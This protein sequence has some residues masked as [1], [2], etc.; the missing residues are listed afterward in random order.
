VAFVGFSI[1]VCLFKGPREPGWFGWSGGLNLRRDSEYPPKSGAD[2][3]KAV[4]GSTGEPAQEEK[5]TS[6]P[7]ST[8][9]GTPSSPN[10]TKQ[11]K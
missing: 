8:E 1:L 10:P 4:D 2:T 6:A 11:N 5:T 3:E 7:T 9:E